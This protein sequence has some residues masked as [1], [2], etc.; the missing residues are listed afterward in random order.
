MAS[1]ESKLSLDQKNPSKDDSDSPGKTLSERKRQ[2]FLEAVFHCMIT[3][4]EVNLPPK[5][6]PTIFLQLLIFTYPSKISHDMLLT[7]LLSHTDRLSKT[8]PHLWVQKF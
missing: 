7:L 8:R 6:S 1:T 3:P 5:R 2:Q 4:P